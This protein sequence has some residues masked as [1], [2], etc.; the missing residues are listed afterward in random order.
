VRRLRHGLGLTL[1]AVGCQHHAAPQQTGLA[2]A[3]AAANVGA[4]TAWIVAPDSVAAKELVDIQS[5]DSTIRIDPP[6]TT[7]D[8]FMGEPVPG[9]EGLR[10]LLRREAAVALGRVQASLRPDGL[11]LRVRDGYRPVRATLEM[12]AWA[13]RIGR[14]GLL[15]SGYIALRSRHNLGAAVDLTLI[16]LASGTALDMGTPIDALTPA[17]HTANASGTPLANR[18]RLA[19]VME[20]QGFAPYSEEWWH[21]SYPVPNPQP[22][23]FVVR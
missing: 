2:T 8:N 22:F 7:A 16:D 13:K 19:N 15:D 11:G 10:I 18:M 21:F 23:D 9:Y 6:Y 4:D 5:I 20:A 17:A 3:L 14:Q 12:V 1:F